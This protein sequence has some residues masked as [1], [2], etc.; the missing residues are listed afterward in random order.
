VRKG[1][2]VSERKWRVGSIIHEKTNF[3][4]SSR[5]NK[6]FENELLKRCLFGLMDL[7]W[8]LLRFMMVP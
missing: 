2:T 7:S 4:E 3:P 8:N 5:N 1:L 6:L